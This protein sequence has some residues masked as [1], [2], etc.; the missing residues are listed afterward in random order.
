M[1]TENP[2]KPSSHESSSRDK[3]ISPNALASHDSTLVKSQGRMKKKLPKLDINQLTQKR[4][5]K[6]V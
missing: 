2:S 1:K 5:A 3:I 4:V 6:K